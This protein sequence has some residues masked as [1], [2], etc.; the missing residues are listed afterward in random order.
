MDTVDVSLPPENNSAKAG[1]ATKSRQFLFGIL[2]SIGWIVL[3]FV[4]QILCTAIFIAAGVGGGSLS[5]AANGDTKGVAVLW[6]LVVSATIQIG[7]LILYLKKDDRYH[8]IGL[9]SFGSM[10]FARTAGL[11]FVLILTAMIANLL[12]ATYV[13][14]GIGMQADMA[15]MLADIPRTPVNIAL[16]FLA[17][18]V[19]APIVEELLFRGLLQ[20]ALARFIPFWG[21]ILL[22]SLVF[23][24]V[25]GQP[26]AIPG[27]MSLSIAFGYLY[28]RTGSLRTN[29]I[30]HML[31]NSAALL[32]TQSM[33]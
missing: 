32:L 31:N 15:K 5:G 21:A 4:L 11:A 17:I 28:H 27:L 23:A 26:Y 8:R 10:S 6:G 9:D 25:H 13:I 33:V 1:I 19:A 12:Y 2:P 20:N 30:L 22:S 18:A 14:P 24:A 16:G 7:L 29:I 3:Y